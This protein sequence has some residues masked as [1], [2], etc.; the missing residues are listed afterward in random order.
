MNARA[1]TAGVLGCALLGTAAGWMGQYTEQ[2]SVNLHGAEQEWR[3]PEWSTLQRYDAGMRV[4]V[5]WAAAARREGA[6]GSGADA[7]P[8]DWRLRAVAVQPVRVA[9]FEPASGGE[10]VRVHEG[11]RLGATLVVE[12]I[13]KRSVMIKDGECRYRQLLDNLVGTAV[14]RAC[15][16]EAASEEEDES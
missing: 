8:E 16:D 1:W 15:D 11:D 3:L 5:P 10:L 13:D 4:S 7:T 12:S 2:G 14:S 6:P 9:L